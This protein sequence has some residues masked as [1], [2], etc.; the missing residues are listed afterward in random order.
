MG[1]YTDIWNGFEARK[2]DP[3]RF[4]ENGIFPLSAGSI[5]RFI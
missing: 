4:L 5:R 3:R 1:G 2:N